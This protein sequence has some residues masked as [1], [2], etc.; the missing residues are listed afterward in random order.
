MQTAS[1]YDVAWKNTG[2]G[3]Y[4]VWATDISGNYTGN[5]IGAVSGNSYAL[6][7]FEPVFKQDLNGDG[8][9][10]LT[11]KVIQTDG[12]TSLTE[13]A[14]Q[15]N[16]VDR[17]GSGPA[18]KYAGV[19]VTAGEFGGWTPIG[20]VQTASGYD[21]AWKNTGTGQYTVW[22]TDSN[23]NY[24]GNLIGAVSGNSFALE[25][26]EPGFN[27]DL[28]GDGLVGPPKTVIQTDTNSF[29]STSLTEVANLCFYL[30]G[31]G[32]SGPALQYNDAN[33]TAGEFG[34][35]TPIGAVQTVSGYD[36]AWKNTG[37]G[38]YTLWTTD[39]SGNYTGNLIGAVSGNSYPLES[40]EPIFNRDLNS[41]GVVGLY[42]TRGTTMQISAPLAGPSGTATIEAGATLELKTTD[43]ASVAFQG[44]TGTLRLDHSSTFS[45]EIFNFTGDGTLAGSDQ[46]DL[47][48]I[49]YA[50]VQDSYA[51]GTLTLTDGS[52]HSAKLSFNG[53]Y[54]LPNFDLVS[55]AN[56]GTIVYDP[57]APSPAGQNPTGPAVPSIANIA[58]LGSYIASSFPTGSNNHGAMM[59]A[60]VMQPHDP[61]VLSNPHH[62]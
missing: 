2:T 18:L 38:Q 5:L 61:S 47:R 40:I 1:G 44:S 27:Q 45:G 55:D 4:T 37:T 59:I 25:S 42:A 60:E 10:G 39:S 41:D 14:N 8:V 20:A 29:G 16:L 36:V 11:T 9:I 28:N 24:T 51:N 19:D 49:K 22:T 13:V 57:P 50:S 12:S 53:S 52:S 30:D 58:L 56:G 54:T 31:R 32:G 46:I 6:E 43:S 33:V 34:N 15:Y 7:S 23:G 62:T 35:W 48:D 3:Q 26:L 17:S 21:V